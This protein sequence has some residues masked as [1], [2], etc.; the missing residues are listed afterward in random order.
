MNKATQ[1]LMYALALM[2]IVKRE[3]PNED[4]V[5]VEDTKPEPKMRNGKTYYNIGDKPSPPPAPPR[6]TG[7]STPRSFFFHGPE[8]YFIVNSPEDGKRILALMNVDSEEWAYG[9]MLS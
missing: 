7:S 8:G 6:A 4:S 3:S 9:P 5:K 1:T 2:A